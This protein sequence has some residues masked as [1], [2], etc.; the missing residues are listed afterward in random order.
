VIKVK[1]LRTNWKRIKA[2]LLNL[3][4]TRKARFLQ[5]HNQKIV[6]KFQ[7]GRSIKIY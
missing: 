5:N 6:F 3:I 1:I 4:T 7:S 2:K